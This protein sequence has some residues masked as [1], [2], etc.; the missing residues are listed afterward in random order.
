METTL[1]AVRITA[2]TDAEW[3]VISFLTPQERKA[4]LVAAA[5]EKHQQ[6]VTTIDAQQRKDA[7]KK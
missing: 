3:Q 6:V 7:R 5:R 2:T 1:R 4:A